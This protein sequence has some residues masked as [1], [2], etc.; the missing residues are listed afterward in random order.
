MAWQSTIIITYHCDKKNR[1]RLQ[2]TEKNA[3]QSEI[4]ELEHFYAQAISQAVQ[5][6]EVKLAEKRLSSKRTFPEF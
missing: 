4:Q 3:T 6:K 1:I 2:K 5:W